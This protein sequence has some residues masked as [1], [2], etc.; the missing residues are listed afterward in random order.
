M[1]EQAHSREHDQCVFETQIVTK[2]R[3]ASRTERMSLY[4]QLYNAYAEAFLESVP[5]GTDY[6]DQSVGF[7]LLGPEARG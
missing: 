6:A 4:G 5:G 7:E 2:L 1:S 3:E